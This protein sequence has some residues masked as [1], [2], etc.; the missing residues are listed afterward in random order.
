MPKILFFKTQFC[1]S[2]SPYWCGF[3]TPLEV[4]N[5]CF[6]AIG[7]RRKTG[8]AVLWLVFFVSENHDLAIE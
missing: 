6:K 7:H 2:Q 4:K 8:M 1:Y 5:P 3:C